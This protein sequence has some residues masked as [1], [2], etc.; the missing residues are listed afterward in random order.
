[1]YVLIIVIL[2]TLSNIIYQ[3]ENYYGYGLPNQI[4]GTI[5]SSIN[6]KITNLT[7][8]V[9]KKNNLGKMINILSSDMNIL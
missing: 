4:R 9:A 6:K 5:I 8:F 7:S 2:L 3:N 1:M